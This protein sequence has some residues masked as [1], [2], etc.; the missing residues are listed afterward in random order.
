LICVCLRAAQVFQ[1]S[2]RRTMWLTILALLVLVNSVV[3]IFS[4]I[5]VIA[6]VLMGLPFHHCLYCMVQ[7]VGDGSIMLGLFVLGNMMIGAALPSWKLAMSWADE[8]SLVRL[9]TR[10]LNLGAICLAGPLLMLLVHLVR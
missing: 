8:K 3:G 1:V 10:L 4:Y 6:P 5:E 9:I 7:N 2:S